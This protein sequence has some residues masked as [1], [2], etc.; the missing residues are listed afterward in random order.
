MSFAHFH[1]LLVA[2][3][4]GEFS[5]DPVDSGGGHSH[6]VGDCPFG[7]ALFTQFPD[8]F[9][10]FFGGKSS[11]FVL[12]LAADALASHAGNRNRRCLLRQ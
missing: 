10:A 4:S 1:A 2:F 6:L 7:E 5:A 8:Q 11:G 9:F 3:F 12:F